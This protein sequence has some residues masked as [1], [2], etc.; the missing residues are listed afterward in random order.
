MVFIKTGSGDYYY[1]KKNGAMEFVVKI[2]TNTLS[3][4]GY[5]V[6]GLRCPKELVGKRVRVKLE[7]LE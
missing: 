4:T 5:I 3:H 2:N 7:I 6:N 1:R